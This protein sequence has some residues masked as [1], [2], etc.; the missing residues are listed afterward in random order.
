MNLLDFTIQTA[1]KAGD[2][3]LKESKN[4]LLIETKSNAND[5]VTN[6]DKASEALIIKEIKKKYPD[7]AIMAEESTFLSDKNAQ[8][9]GSSKYIWIIDPIDGTTNFTRN[10]PFY[11]VSIGVFKLS[12]AESSDNYDYLEGELQIGVVHAPALNQTFYAEK[13]KGAY[14][15][16]EKIS[17]SKVKTLSDSIFATGFPYKN[18]EINLPYFDKM[19][20]N[21]R[22]GRRLGAASLDMA[23][24]ASGYLDLF[25]EFGL[26]AWD[27]A[28]GALI[29]EEAGGTVSDTNG[30][31]IDLFG[32]DILTS[33]GKVHK[34]SIKLFA[35]L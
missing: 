23:Y 34:E 33:N 2:L 24:V 30:N 27:V 6:V 12:K 15:D 19:A 7:H 26:K 10:I 13:G 4:K 22:G 11:A 16:G 25:W 18:G 9:L 28:A 8:N 31:L 14:K 1:K 21:T 20:R 29:I 35:K 5:L 32:G 17:V 3:I